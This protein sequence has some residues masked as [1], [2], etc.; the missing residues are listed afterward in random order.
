MHEK[1]D[2]ENSLAISIHLAPIPFSAANLPFI[3]LWFSVQPKFPNLHSISTPLEGRATTYVKHIVVDHWSPAPPLS[4]CA[5][6]HSCSRF[7]H[8]CFHFF[9]SIL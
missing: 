5:S 9:L 4:G 7:H 8:F 6:Y 2:I 3:G 1:R